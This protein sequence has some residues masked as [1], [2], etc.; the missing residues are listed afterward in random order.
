M[1]QKRPDRTLGPGHDTFWN[2]CDRG[3]LRLQRCTRCGTYAWPVVQKCEQCAA[4]DLEFQTVSG[5]GKVV[6]W[7]SFVQDYYRGILPVPYDT[8]MVELEEGPMFL[9]N[10]HEF[11]ENEIAFGMPV[12][13]AFIACEDSAGRFQLP[14]FRKAKA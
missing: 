13:V 12:E 2:G 7:C 5:R 3:E 6:S 1:V 14:V 4:D 8:V 11:G 9:S 10:P